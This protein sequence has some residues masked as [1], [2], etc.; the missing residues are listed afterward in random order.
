MF[1]LLRLLIFTCI[2]FIAGVLFE[3]N[4]AQETCAARSGLWIDNICVGI[5][6]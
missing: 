4:A 2:A 5:E 3:R 6:Q 1:R